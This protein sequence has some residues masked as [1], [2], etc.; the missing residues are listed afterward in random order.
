MVDALIDDRV[1]MAE[2]YACLCVGYR[3]FG[4]QDGEST[5]TLAGRTSST[6]VA[7]HWKGS[8]TSLAPAGPCTITDE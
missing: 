3:F 4:I 5:R 8:G 2:S 7:D 6:L 1:D